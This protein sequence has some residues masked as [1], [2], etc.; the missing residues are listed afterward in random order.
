MNNP[1]ATL[2]IQ[3]YRP[4][5]AL[6]HHAFPVS[7]K[8]YL[9]LRQPASQGRRTL[10]T[11]QTMPLIR[12]SEDAPAE[13][14]SVDRARAWEELAKWVQYCVIS[15]DEVVQQG[16]YENRLKWQKWAHLGR[17]RPGLDDLYD[18]RQDKDT[19]ERLRPLYR[20]VAEKLTNVIGPP[21]R[22]DADALYP[23]PFEDEGLS[24]DAR[25]LIRD[26]K[27]IFGPDIV[28]D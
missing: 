11:F 28:R 21:S 17:Q 20:P 14:L 19:L 27:A 24:D 4:R 22:T 5:R 13:P 23:N 1:F 9:R 10:A 25:R 6:T 12:R 15:A 26:L 16:Q 18:W 7:E 8:L 3:R 2:D